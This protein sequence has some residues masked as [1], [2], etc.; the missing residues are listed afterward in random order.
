MLINDLAESF[1]MGN[2][3]FQTSDTI[4][5]LY[6]VKLNTNI[7]GKVNIVDDRLP[8]WKISNFDRTTDLLDKYIIIARD[9]YAGDKEYYGF[10]SSQFDKKLIFDLVVNATS[11]EL[12]NFDEYIEKKIKI[13]RTN[14]KR[15]TINIGEID[16][17]FG[18]VNAKATIRRTP[19]KLEG[20]YKIAITFESELGSFTLPTV[21]FGLEKDK[22]HVYAV[23]AKKEKEE[24]KLAKNLDRYFRKFNKDVDLEELEGKVSPNALASTVVFFEY[25]KSLGINKVVAPVYMP[26]RYFSRIIKNEELD[27]ISNEEKQEQEDLIDRDQFNMTNR[28]SANLLRYSLH[29]N[30]CKFDFNDITDEINLR[31]VKTHKKDFSENEIYNFQNQVNKLLEKENEDEEEMQ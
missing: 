19:S 23:Q 25:L 10:L 9:F 6:Y 26:V 14:V 27:N 2:I 17:P 13:L 18:K 5:W 7:E 24:N 1:N 4:P 3:A 11:Y 22:A 28:F 15:E 29:F 12:E 8:I 16:F 30:E 31:L 20:P 21:T